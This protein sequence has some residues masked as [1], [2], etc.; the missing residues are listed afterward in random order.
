MADYASDVTAEDCLI[1][2]NEVQG[3]D[4]SSDGGGVRAFF[5]NQ[6]TLRRCTISANRAAGG[7]GG[8]IS[9]SWCTPT[10]EK[11]IISHS[12]AGKGLYCDDQGSFSVSCTDLYGN[13]G[14]DALC[15][16][17]LGNNFSLNPLFCDL[18]N[19]NYYLQT[20]SPCAAGQHPN[21]SGA[22]GGSRLGAYGTGCAPLDVDDAG[23]AT[24]LTSRPNPFR[25]ATEIGFSLP[26]EAKA[27]VRVFDPAGREL[28]TLVD[29]VLPAGPHRETWDGADASGRLVPSGV[30]FY[31]LSIDGRKETRRLVVAR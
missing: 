3:T 2:N 5:A 11:C 29:R 15:G 7:L 27:T 4:V 25:T 28:R 1:A 12:T 22:C 31:Q 30:Y 23:P 26:R 17:D 6:L 20:A 9:A 18:A 8:G 19:R 16:S 24:S 13:A 14:G 21:G 10:I